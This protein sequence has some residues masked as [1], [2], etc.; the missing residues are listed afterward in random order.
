[1]MERAGAGAVDLVSTGEEVAVNEDEDRLDWHLE[2]W[3]SGRGYA[4]DESSRGRLMGGL[5]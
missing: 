2:W 5:S 3:S 1:M 4:P